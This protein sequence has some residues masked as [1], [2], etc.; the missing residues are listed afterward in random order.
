MN[1]PPIINGE[2]ASKPKNQPLSQET[3]QSL[4]E[5]GEVFRRIHRRLISE[6]YIIRDGKL[7]KPVSSAT[8]NGAKS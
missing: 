2:I 6:G 8:N 5:L 1:K 4:Q 3:V 7:I